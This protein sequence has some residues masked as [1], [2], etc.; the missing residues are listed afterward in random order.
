MVALKMAL[1]SG[2]KRCMDQAFSDMEHFEVS[3]KLNS[4][5]NSA[6][7]NDINM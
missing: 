2:N 6:S 1:I 7:S 4:F 5:L 3:F